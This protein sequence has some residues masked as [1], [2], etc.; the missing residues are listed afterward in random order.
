MFHISRLTTGKKTE[1]DPYVPYLPPY[2]REKDG[3]RS[4]CSISPALPPGKRRR[5]IPMFH[6]SRLTTGKKTEIDPYVPYLP[7]YHREKDGDRSLCSISPTLT[8]GKRRRSIPM[9]HISRLTTGKK[10]EIDPSVPYLPPYHREK[11]GDRSLCSI[12]PALTLGKQ[13][14]IEPYVHSLPLSLLTTLEK[15]GD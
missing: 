4:L 8:L 5:S 3:D 13:S 7:P 9:F 6:I 14:G 15:N 11:D 1:I 2:H 10:T 12:S